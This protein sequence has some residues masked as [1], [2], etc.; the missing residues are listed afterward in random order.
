[1]NTAL[2]APSAFLEG[3]VVPF[4][5]AIP[6]NV[7]AELRAR[8]R[9][10]CFAPAP[11]ESGWRYGSDANYLREL[12]KF[13]A[14]SFEW[15]AHET[16]INQMPQ[17]RTNID[18]VPIHFVHARGRGPQALPIILTHGWPG[19]FLE[20]ERVLPLLT[21]PGMHGGDPQDAFDVVVPS[22][23]GFGF[24]G[25]PA[26][27]GMTPLRV[28]ELWSQLM[29]RVLGYSRYAAH[30]GDIGSSVTARL[31]YIDPEHVVGIH[32]TYVSGSA[33][34]RY[35]GQGATPL[36]DGERS[37]QRASEQWSDEE[38][39]YAHLQRT[40]PQLLA[41]ALADSPM[42]LAVWLLDK[43]RSWSDC[44]SHIENRYSKDDL[45]TIVTLYWVTETIGS[46]M[47]LYADSREHPWRLGP[48]DR[49]SIP[50][51]V[52]L[53]PADM[54][55]PPREW[56]ERVQHPAMDRDAAR[57][58]LRRVRGTRTACPGDPSVF[59]SASTCKPHAPHGDASTY[60]SELEM[61]GA[62]TA[63]TEY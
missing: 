29:T 39:A 5:V 35:L 49:V 59:P 20:M 50:T 57:R 28:A 56:G 44:E 11:P 47:R 16:R 37:F 22:L 27:K 34:I 63:S 46:S 51:G 1:M 13:W 25:D 8:I 30:G 40:K 48:N 33:V 60:P 4:R 54:P 52:A 3:E 7:L 14:E 38:G 18:G 6:E 26:Q 45:L 23:P 32:L 2:P 41:D 36:T 19:S 9:S 17:F 21:D 62:L 53:F 58:P 43:Y 55:A 42:G 31:G 12:A 61:A 15:K 10:T 24:S